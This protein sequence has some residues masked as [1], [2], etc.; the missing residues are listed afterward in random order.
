MSDTTT[1]LNYDLT[2]DPFPLQAGME[3]VMLTVVVSNPKPS[4][5]V[6]LRGIAVQ[7]PVGPNA[8]E[9]TADAA[10]ITAAAP[11]GWRL[12][13]T[14]PGPGSV[15]YVF[16][17]VRGQGPLGGEGLVFSLADFVV[18]TQPGVAAVMVKE[19]SNGDPTTQLLVSKFEARYQIG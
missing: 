16:T 15:D 1:K 17:P 4:Q 6:T 5:P 12:S 10:P 3:S 14:R 7:L 19:G 8:S 11:A 2:T 13:S 9:L 18:N